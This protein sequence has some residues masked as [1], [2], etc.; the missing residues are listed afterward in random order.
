MSAEDA[1]DARLGK[2]YTARVDRLLP[3]TNLY[4]TVAIMN[5]FYVSRPSDRISITTEAGCQSVC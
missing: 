4:V 5:N 2:T 3:L 1:S